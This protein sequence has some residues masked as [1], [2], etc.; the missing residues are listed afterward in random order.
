M[1]LKLLWPNG[2]RGFC[3]IMGSEQ[4]ER[5]YNQ[6]FR[7]TPAQDLRMRRRAEAILAEFRPHS[8]SRPKILEIGCGTGQLAWELAQRTSGDVLAVDLSPKF[9]NSASH[10]Y[11]LPNLEF[12]VLDLSE[13]LPAEFFQSFDYVVGNGI[14]HHL[15]LRLDSALR[16]F[17]GILRPGGKLIFWEPNLYNP[18]VALIFSLPSLRRLAHLEPDEFAFSAPFIRKKLRKCGFGEV[19]VAPRDFL[20]P[21]V[22]EWMVGPSVRLGALAEQIPGVR[23][24]AQSLFISAVRPPEEDR[25]APPRHGGDRAA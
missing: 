7:E 6:G 5:G 13:D 18:Y 17:G 22:P 20:L 24:M 4:D 19:R 15:F 16:A 3:D 12:R 25:L 10:R 9:V 2:N 8:Q 11:V 21:T 1:Q 14:L 23:W